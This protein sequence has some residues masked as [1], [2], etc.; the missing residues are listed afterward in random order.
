MKEIH[1]DGFFF[2]NDLVS[3]FKFDEIL[4]FDDDVRHVAVYEIFFEFFHHIK[5]VNKKSVFLVQKQIL[6]CS[7][8]IQAPL[9]PSIHNF[10]S[11]KLVN[12]V[13]VI[14]IGKVIIIV[15][16]VIV[17]IKVVKVVVVI[18]VDVVGIVVLVFEIRVLILVR[19]SMR[20]LFTVASMFVSFLGFLAFIFLV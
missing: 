15:I 6:L 9:R 7:C 19:G 12:F 16:K 3:F 13:R 8:S 18:K 10:H 14:E 5:L 1:D 20:A 11:K 2:I 17:I 4:S